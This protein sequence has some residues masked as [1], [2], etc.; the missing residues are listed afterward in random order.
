LLGTV[1]EEKGVY[2]VYNLSY[3]EDGISKNYLGICGPFNSQLNKAN[4]D[5][6]TSYADFELKKED[7]LAQVK[8]L[9]ESM[10]KE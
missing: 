6:Y 10:K 1:K 3:L 2:Y 8:I 4:F 7:W 5:S 9:I